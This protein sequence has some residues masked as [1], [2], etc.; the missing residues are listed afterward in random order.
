M[1]RIAAHLGS[2]TGEL[3]AVDKRPCQGVTSAT[4]FEH[5]M[6]RNAAKSCGQRAVKRSCGHLA[7]LTKWPLTCIYSVGTA[8]F[9]SLWKLVCQGVRPVTWVLRSAVAGQ[10]GWPA[11]GGQQAGGL[12]WSD[13]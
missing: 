6:P 9:D 11:G 1:N 5:T 13:G 4:T 3:L 8:G 7:A 10:A 2:R 12:R